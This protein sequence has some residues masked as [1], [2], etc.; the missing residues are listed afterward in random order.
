MPCAVCLVPL[1]N[2]IMVPGTDLCPSGWTLQYWGFLVAAKTHLYP[3]DYMCLAQDP[4]GNLFVRITETMDFYT[5]AA[6]CNGGLRCPPYL[7]SKT[8]L[9]AICSK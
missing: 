9:C 2:T 1:S 5:V 4:E 3:S 6:W 7:W 8:I